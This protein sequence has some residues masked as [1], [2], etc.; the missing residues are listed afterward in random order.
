MKKI[1]LFAMALSLSLI[2]FSCSGDDGP[3]GPAG[4]AGATGAAGPAGPT[5]V[6]GIAG[7]AGAKMYTYGSRTFTRV[8]NYTIPDITPEE[9]ANSHIS[10]FHYRNGYW[11]PV[12]GIGNG[13]FYQVDAFLSPGPTSC[14]FR[15]FLYN[16]D[17]TD[18]TTQTNWEAF[19]IIVMPI[20]SDN[21][22]VLAGNLNP[23][24]WSDYNAV[25]KHFNLPE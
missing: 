11:L 23:I 9:V 8:E 25:A 1:L 18:Y 13:A 17:G 4:P 16:F 22:T 12:P 20:P 24:N 2:T 3:A 6:Q 19:R 7:N 10:A 21:I 15:I 5:G 14:T